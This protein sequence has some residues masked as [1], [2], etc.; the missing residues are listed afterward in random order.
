[1]ERSYLAEH[2]YSM[3]N[4]TIHNSPQLEGNQKPSDRINKSCSLFTQWNAIKQ[5]ILTYSKDESHKMLKI[6]RHK[7]VH[8]V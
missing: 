3:S 5:S 7:K 1:M 6:A 8:S 2:T 4:S